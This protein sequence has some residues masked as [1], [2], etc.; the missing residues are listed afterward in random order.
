M[1]LAN[2]YGSEPYAERLVG[3]TPTRGTLKIIKKNEKQFKNHSLRGMRRS[4]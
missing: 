1:K 4:R 3:S 2:M